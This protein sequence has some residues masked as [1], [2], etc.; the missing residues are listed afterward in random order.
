MYIPVYCSFDFLLHFFQHHPLDLLES[1]GESQ[2]LAH[3]HLHDVILN[4]MTLQTD[5]SKEKIDEH[6]TNPYILRLIKSQRIESNIP[7]FMDLRC[8][9][10]LYLKQESKNVGLYLM[11]STY[12]KEKLTELQEKSGSYFIGTTTN[13]TSLFQDNVHDLMSGNKSTWAFL[14]Q[15]L[16]PHHSLI[17]ADPYLFKE[18][19]AKVNRLLQQV[20]PTG[21]KAPYHLT[22]IGSSERNGMCLSEIAIERAVKEIKRAINKTNANATVEYHIYNRRDFHDRLIITN[23]IMIY[24]GSGLDAINEKGEASKDSYWVGIRPFKRLNHNGFQGAF[25]EKMIQGK[26]ERLKKWIS[27]SNQSGS[28]NPLLN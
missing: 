20:V 1:G 23:N 9:E 2:A 26:L 11:S 4:G 14:Q 22:L 12:S 16:T 17:I 7:A 27:S 13:I 21:L 10:N 5:A 19:A 25:C 8:N 15:M 28:S 24:S 18:K 6:F 3:L